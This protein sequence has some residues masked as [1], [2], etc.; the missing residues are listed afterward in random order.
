MPRKNYNVK[1][2]EA[3]LAGPAPTRSEA[4]KLAYSK[5]MKA[6]F[7]FRRW[8]PIAEIQM[9]PGERFVTDMG[10][11][12]Q[13]GWVVREV[14]AITHEPIIKAGKEVRMVLGRA[15]V[16]DAHEFGALIRLPK[17]FRG[18]RKPKF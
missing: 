4:I 1:S 11:T 12:G 10:T 16:L 8:E 3:M 15:L 5:R 13:H 14:D 9:P 2:V 6:F 18:R 7:Q 17:G